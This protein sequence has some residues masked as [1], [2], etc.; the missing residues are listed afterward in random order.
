MADQ[1]V[2]GT[3]TPSGEITE[4]LIE[5]DNPGGDL[6]VSGSLVWEA[7]FS[8]SAPDLAGTIT[9]VGDLSTSDNA[10]CFPAI[11][12]CVAEPEPAVSCI[13]TCE[14]TE[15]PAPSSED[16][17]GTIIPVGRLILPGEECEPCPDCPECPECPDCPPT[18]CEDCTSI[19]LLVDET[20]TGGDDSNIDGRTPDGGGVVALAVGLWKKGYTQAVATTLGIVSGILNVVGSAINNITAYV[21]T[22]T[23]AIRNSRVIGRG[24][25]TDVDSDDSI[26]VLGAFNDVTGDG[27]ELRYRRAATSGGITVLQL[28]GWSGGAPSVQLTGSPSLA[29][30]VAGVQHDLQLDIEDTPGGG[31]KLY[32]SL[33]GE[34]LLIA[35]DDPNFGGYGTGLYPGVAMVNAALTI[36]D[37]NIRRVRVYDQSSVPCPCASATQ[38]S[39]SSDAF[40]GGDDANVDSRPVD[41]D[42]NTALQNGQWTKVR[43]GEAWTLD[44]SSGFLVYNH[45]GSSSPDDNGSHYAID[46]IFGL[47]DDYKTKVIF[48]VHTFPV[49]LEQHVAALARFSNE[50]GGV[51]GYKF[52]AKP[53]PDAWNGP[54]AGGWEYILYRVRAG[55]FVVIASS[56]RYYGETNLDTDDDITIQVKGQ[57]ICGFH[58]NKLV[59]TFLDDPAN[60]PNNDNDREPI[61]TGGSP[62]VGILDGSHNGSFGGDGGSLK[63]KKVIVTQ[64]AL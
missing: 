41:G 10:Q 16:L 33:D 14:P 64:D 31:K 56:T 37:T 40:G 59:V 4:F 27:Y 45:N 55:I 62:G 47:G 50:T 60:N 18:E 51:T 19:T 46:N 5:A 39:I 36:G 48:Q 26:S 24:A 54:G 29:P 9:P 25:F 1:S 7:N 49:D 28:H 43:A 3:I 15:V 22:E 13:D 35:D 61:L 6:F 2:D 17:E 20:F 52:L 30:A 23:D 21:I 38:V 8:V 34:L 32:G 63:V 53:I 57:R 44:I 42:G 11:Y 12:E 58:G